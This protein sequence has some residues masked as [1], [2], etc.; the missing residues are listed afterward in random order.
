MPGRYDRLTVNAA[1]DRT[2]EL[3]E[4]FRKLVGP[5]GINGTLLRLIEAWVKEQESRR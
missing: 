4:K 2:I 3:L 5:R 1:S